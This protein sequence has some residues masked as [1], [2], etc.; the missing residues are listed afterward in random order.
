MAYLPKNK[1]NINYT[2]GGEYLFN[3][4]EYIGKYITLLDSG[5]TFAGDNIQN[6][7]G[8]LL[9]I[10]L[11]KNDR[12]IRNNRNNLIY[13]ILNPEVAASEEFY[14]D[15]TSSNPI[16][17]PLDYSKG[18]F[19]RYLAIRKNTKALIEISLETY[20]EYQK[21]LY[22]NSLYDVFRIQW[23]LVENN[24]QE[25]IRNLTYYNTKI[26]GIYDFF[27]D[28]SQYGLKNGIINLRGGG[29]KR[30]YPGGEFV[31]DSLPIAYQIGN[32]DSNTKVNDRVPKYQFCGNCIFAL[33]GK[34]NKWN[35][36]IKTN[37]WCAAWKNEVG[38]QE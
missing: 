20:M 6:L 36:E 23:S 1:Y 10:T 18:V 17:T 13:T 7:Q 28:K 3:G 19:T 22:D 34:C 24:E 25:N 12:V 26:R 14:K 16:P 4:E 2:N 29:S 35:A 21:G 11:P 8:R 30:L 32:T 15:I 37:Y 27:S 38:S 9:P 5:K 31:P 33:N